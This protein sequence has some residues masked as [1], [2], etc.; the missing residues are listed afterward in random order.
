M[1]PDKL[2]R[3]S[4]LKT[5]VAANDI[6][7]VVFEAAGRR[8]IPAEERR[9]ACPLVPAWVLLIQRKIQHQYIDA[10]FPKESECRS[11]RMFGD[12]LLDLLRV[13]AS[14]FCYARRLHLG[15]CRTDL[16]IQPGR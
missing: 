3:G 4:S 7:A 13:G 11:L 6:K 2:R 16:R 14:H 9:L 8:G 12:Q 15:I 5:I 10:G 1:I